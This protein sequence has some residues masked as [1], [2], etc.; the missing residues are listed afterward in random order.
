VKVEGIEVDFHWPDRKL[1]IEIDGPPHLRPPSK[2]DDPARD[3]QLAAAG[4]TVLRCKSEKDAVR[5]LRTE[6]DRNRP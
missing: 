5:K 6:I 3:A 4:Y 1:V 2:V